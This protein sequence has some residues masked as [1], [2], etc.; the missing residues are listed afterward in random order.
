MAHHRLGQSAQAVSARAVFDDLA[1]KPRWKFVR[2]VLSWASE[3]KELMG[4]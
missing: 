1:A 2:E 3:T 4:E